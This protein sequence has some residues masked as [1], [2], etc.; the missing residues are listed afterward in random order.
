MSIARKVAINTGVQILGQASN[1][2]IGI[3]TSILLVRYLGPT[4][5]G[6]YAFVTIYIAMFSMIN[7]FGMGT[8]LARDIAKNKTKADC[9]IGNA[10]LLKSLIGLVMMSFSIIVVSLLRYPSDIRLYVYIISFT[11]I[12]SAPSV[13]AAI[14]QVNLQMGYSSFCNAVGRLL[15][16]GVIGYTIWSQG[17]ILNL[18]I[19]SVVA[20]GIIT[21]MLL[22]F[23]RK[24]VTLNMKVNIPLSKHLFR[25]SFPMG[26][27]L[28]IGFYIHKVDILLLSR[29][30][31]NAAVGFYNAAYK[32][33]DIG[34]SLPAIL[35]ISL[36]PLF[37]EYFSNSREK[38]I[39]VYQKSIDLLAITFIPIAIVVTIRARQIIELIYGPEYY[40][41]TIALQILVWAVVLMSINAIFVNLLIAA[42]KQRKMITLYSVALVVNI[43]LNLVGIPIFSYR[44]SAVA[45]LICEVVV[46]YPLLRFTIQEISYRPSFLVALK[47]VAAVVPAVG[48][49]FL[50]PGLHVFLQLCL[51]LLIYMSI[52]FILRGIT[53]GDLLLFSSKRD[54]LQ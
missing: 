47:S 46:F 42:G 37:S 5:F 25:E 16:L 19:G 31:T 45:S 2:G 11:L 12:I 48:L 20:S 38:L 17:G 6:K 49:L 34:M 52:L 3:I 14:F 10:I 54:S 8:I 21:L 50:I 51:F 15:F 18:V 44:V 22:L 39:I 33:V 24:F 43:I 9:L 41:S 7:N 32:F 1:Y 35:L 26:L 30:D 27:L 40:P 28:I 13:V 36:L 4:E 23:S 29:M 53:Y